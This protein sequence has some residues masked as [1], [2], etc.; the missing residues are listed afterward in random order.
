MSTPVTFEVEVDSHAVVIDVDAPSADVAPRPF[1]RAFFT[2]TSTAVA[3][4]LDEPLAEVSVDTFP[5]V[6]VAAAPGARGLQGLPGEGSPVVGEVLVGDLDGVNTEFTT[7]NAYRPGT[8]AVCLNGL[9]EVRGVGYIESDPTT[10]TLGDPPLP[11][12][13]ITIDYVI[14]GEV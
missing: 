3:V 12:D 10:I 8:T 14:A 11:G 9:R 13:D 4:Q 6:V 5:K 2:P 1:P 7:A